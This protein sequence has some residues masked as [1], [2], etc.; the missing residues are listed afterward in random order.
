M[1]SIQAAKATSP[2]FDEHLKEAYRVALKHLE[3]KNEQEEKNPEE[4]D[5]QEKGDKQ[6]EGDKQDDDEQLIDSEFVQVDE[7]TKKGKKQ[8]WENISAIVIKWSAKQL[9]AWLTAASLCVTSA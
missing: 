3:E 4:G 8:N 2:D 7:E 5:E 9:R 1:Q 6:E